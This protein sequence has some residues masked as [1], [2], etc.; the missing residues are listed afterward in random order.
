[1]PST[2]PAC[3][4]ARLTDVAAKLSTSKEVA[5]WSTAVSAEIDLLHGRGCRLRESAVRWPNQR[6]IAKAN[7]FCALVEPELIRAS[8]ALRRVGAMFFAKIPSATTH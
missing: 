6:R 3:R 2:N 5:A 8:D 4:L 1:M 7:D